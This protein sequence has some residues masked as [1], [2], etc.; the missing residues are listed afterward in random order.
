MRQSTSPYLGDSFCYWINPSQD[1]NAHGGYVPSTVF[2]DRDG[3]YPMMGNGACAEPWLWGDT[4]EK[5]E[6]VCKRVNANK[7]GLTTDE[8]DRILVSSMFGRFGHHA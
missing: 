1:P 5:A 8:I 4:L 3:H 7:L 6:E 2:E